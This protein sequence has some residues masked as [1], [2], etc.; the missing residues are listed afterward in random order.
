MAGISLTGIQQGTSLHQDITSVNLLQ[1]VRAS[2]Q[3]CEDPEKEYALLS[4]VLLERATSFMRVFVDADQ[5]RTLTDVLFMALLPLRSR[6]RKPTGT[7]EGAMQRMKTLLRTAL[8]PERLTLA[9]RKHLDDISTDALLDALCN[10]VAWYPDVPFGKPR[11][12]SFDYLTDEQR[13]AYVMDENRR[14][15]RMERAAK[16]GGLQS[17]SDS[18]EEEDERDAAKQLGVSVSGVNEIDLDWD[19]DVKETTV[20]WLPLCR[21]LLPIQSIWLMRQKRQ[22]IIDAHTFTHKWLSGHKRLLH[23][24][25]DWVSILPGH[26]RVAE[27]RDTYFPRLLP[28]GRRE[29]MLRFSAKGYSSIVPQNL[30]RMAVSLD[31]YNAAVQDMSRPL[32]ELFLRDSVDLAREDISDGEDEDAERAR[33][34]QN[35]RGALLMHP[36]HWTDLHIAWII[37]QFDSDLRDDPGISFK[38]RFLYQDYQ[39]LEHPFLWTEKRGEVGRATLREPIIIEL[40]DRGTWGVSVAPKTLA[41]DD[42]GERTFY[43]T[44]AHGL[45]MHECSNLL[46]AIQCWISCMAQEPYNFKALDEDG[47]ERDM[48]RTLSPFLA[49]NA[50]AD[51]V[52]DAMAMR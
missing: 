25:W 7:A 26:F 4:H 33:E 45:E 8:R 44:L 23:K 19:D 35:R 6:F 39:F 28:P 37:T 47:M 40:R 30:L 51:M 49:T 22:Q 1:K 38:E 27:T 43:E 31:E 36:K 41:V 18:D 12:W 21:L 46:D 16:G 13:N 24:V 29:Q 52:R 10:F 48:S 34:R 50:V 9:Q 11:P 20:Q 17:D 42:R 14:I 5:K 32:K 15:K 2:L 3:H